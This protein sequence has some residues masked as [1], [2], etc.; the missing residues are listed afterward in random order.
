M[1]SKSDLRKAIK[2]QMEISGFTESD[3][4]FSVEKCIDKDRIRQLHAPLRNER[5]AKNKVF[6]LKHGSELVKCFASGT[7]VVPTKIAPKL[8]EVRPETREADLFR[9]ATCMWSVPV[10]QGFGRR[11]R[12]LVTDSYNDKL[13][14][15]FALGDPVFNLS[16]RDEWIGWSFEDRKERLVHVMD[17]FVV[18]A[19]PPYSQLIGGKLV[20]ALMASTEVKR[21]YERKYLG[22]ESIIS[23]KTK[24]ARLVL[25]TTTSALGRSSL[26]NRL[27][28]PGGPS[29]IKVG[30]TRGYGH[31][32]VSE[33]L[34]GLMRQFLKQEEHPYAAGHK[35]GMGPNWR[36][37][38]VRTA[39]ESVGLDGDAILKHGIEREVYGIPLASNWNAILMG[40]M[41]NVLST[42]RPAAEVADY[43][44]R[45]WIVPRSERDQT[46]QSV[47]ADKTLAE[48]LANVV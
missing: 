39:I 14:G 24:R 12:F 41:K 25:L 40:E 15:L 10:S 22:R 46:Y 7:E 27:V 21:A 2:E 17:A 26:Y 4:G 9:F 28:I 32:Q 23:G 11:M 13:I 36:F 44:L 1:I 33:E 45:R 8:V 37:R 19:A 29:F 30:K 38:V 18:G 47:V 20:A 6:I 35:F 34:F 43:C 48:V 16:A 5:L 42:T 3:N 31:F